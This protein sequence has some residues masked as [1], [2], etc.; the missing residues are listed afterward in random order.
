MQEGAD[1]ASEFIPE[2]GPGE[3]GWLFFQ[4]PEQKVATNRMHVDFVAGDR[5]AEALPPGATVA[6]CYG[7]ARGIRRSS[8]HW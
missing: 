3:Q 6:A 4:V 2:G 7:R 1:A 8:P 5:E